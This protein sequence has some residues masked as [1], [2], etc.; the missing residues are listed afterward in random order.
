MDHIPKCTR[1]RITD[2]LHGAGLNGA[3]A[4]DC[5]GWLAGLDA[6]RLPHLDALSLGECQHVMGRIDNALDVRL[7]V[8]EYREARRSDTP[9]PEQMRLEGVLWL[10]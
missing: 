2:A 10:F 4:V 8:S 7:L 3:A 9:T 1:E 5:A 6:G